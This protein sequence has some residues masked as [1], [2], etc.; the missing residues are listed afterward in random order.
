MHKDRFNGVGSFEDYLY[1]SM[2]KDYSKFLTET[3]NMG[4]RYDGIA[5]F[6]SDSFII[7]PG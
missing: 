1:T 6:F 4:N 3:R 2:T 7:Q 5:G